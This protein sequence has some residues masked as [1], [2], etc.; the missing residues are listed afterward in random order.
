[1][2]D[3]FTQFS[4]VPSVI[5]E[6]E[7]PEEFEG[8]W[9][10]GQVLVG[11][12]DAV[13]Q[14]SSPLRHATELHSQLLT[15]IGNR[16][17]LFLYS[18]GGPDHRL[19]Y[20]SVQLSLI[21]LFLNL[22]LDFLV[23]CRTAPNH[24]WKNPVERIMSI[25]NLGLQCVG[26]MREK[27]PDA[28]ESAISNANTLQ[29]L[30]DSGIS[31]NDTLLTL[32]PVIELLHGIFR[33]LELKGCPFDVYEAATEEQI[34]EFWS[35]LLLIDSTLS[36]DD[37][38]KKTIKAKAKISD[39]MKHCCRIRHYSFQVKKCG[40]PSCSICK[41]VRMDSE[42]F[43]T[44]H[45]MPDPIPGDDDHHKRFVEVYGLDTTEEHRPSLL[46]AR[47]TAL[48][49]LG[50][51]P[52]QQH[53]RNVGVLIQCDECGMWRLLFSKQKL[54]YQELSEL[55][56]SLDD[57]SYSCG[58]SLS[59]LDLP[60]RLKGVGVKDH[61]CNDPTEKLYYS[62]DFEPICYW[63]ASENVPESTE[64]FP[65]CVGCEGKALVHRPKKRQQ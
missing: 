2:N 64:Y 65:V 15:R 54:N 60:G 23:A 33:R 49:S 55:E 22:N 8:S 39:F 34:E 10:Q 18:D 51:T 28:F 56:R 4:I 47:K 61:R 35:V 38:T 44:L 27:L 7:I 36:R 16:S 3:D 62:C 26:L 52:S 19:T 50:F 59:E 48:Q 13:F 37:S 45:F 31:G 58:L 53:V 42:L 25:I 57:V 1:M 63:C 21:A 32:K 9:Y 40:L 46:T 6:V 29:Q 20:V 12:K 5:L 43:K 14:G 30:R 11:T 17:I 41:P 24:S